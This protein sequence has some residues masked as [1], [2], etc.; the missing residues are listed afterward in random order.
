MTYTA[1]L[2]TIVFILLIA[3]IVQE[4]VNSNKHEKLVNQLKQQGLIEEGN[5]HGSHS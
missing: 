5:R 3:C 2:W 1:S 4:I